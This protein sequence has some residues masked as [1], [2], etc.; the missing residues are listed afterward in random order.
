MIESLFKNKAGRGK[1]MKSK[2]SIVL[3]LNWKN[4]YEFMKQ[5]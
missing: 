1:H 3:N 4:Q 5:L 2:N